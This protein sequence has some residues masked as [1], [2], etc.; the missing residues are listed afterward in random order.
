M[1]QPA[2]HVALFDLDDTLYPAATGLWQAIRA[3][4]TQYMVDIVGLDPETAVTLRQRYYHAYGA[5]L[6]GLRLEHGV[7]ADDFLRYVHAVPVETY[8]QPDP[9]LNAMLARLPLKKV[10]FTNADVQHAERV[11]NRLGVARHFSE[12]V[13]VRARQLLFKP[14]PA[15]YTCTFEHL[16]VAPERCVY[17]DDAL[18]NLRPA[19]ALGCL[20]ILVNP[21]PQPDLTGAHYQVAQVHQAERI[22][23]A[24]MV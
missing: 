16:R 22:V 7:D 20:T 10:I 4:I 12:I 19:R 3:R 24:H 1:L 2:L 5:A 11:L 23:A 13:D 9:A 6:P 18:H 15:A 8:L 21:E 17:L 14:N